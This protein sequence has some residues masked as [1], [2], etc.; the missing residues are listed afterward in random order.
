MSKK[1]IFSFILFSFVCSTAFAENIPLQR[2]AHSL[3]MPPAGQM[4]NG[5]YDKTKT[6]VM[7]GSKFALTTT[8]MV[9]GLTVG[10]PVTWILLG[11]IAGIHIWSS[12][13]AYRNA[14]GSP[15]PQMILIENTYGQ[16]LD[17]EKILEQ[18]RIVRLGI[19]EAVKQS[20]VL[21]LQLSPVNSGGVPV[22]VQQQ[23]QVEKWLILSKQH[24]LFE[25]VKIDEVRITTIDATDMMRQAQN[26][27]QQ[28]LKHSR[29]FSFN[30]MSD[31][32]LIS[33]KP[34]EFQN[35]AAN[36]ALL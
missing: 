9:V 23:I 25:E 28:L 1:A 3:I 19:R 8:A 10:G 12:I 17:A 33:E 7:M 16:L 2:A 26:I 24:R 6:K 34:S 35:I 14:D 27:E 5:E 18:S 11:P 13:D 29:S 4:M 22:L 20:Q 36:F 32:F 30:S 21:S 31:Q 15:S